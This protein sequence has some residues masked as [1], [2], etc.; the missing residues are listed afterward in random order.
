MSHKVEWYN[1]CLLKNGTLQ[2][3]S[4]I[5]SKYAVVGKEIVITTDGKKQDWT[6]HTVGEKVDGEYLQDRAHNSACIWTATSGPCP[7]GNK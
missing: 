6:V 1:Q 5:P 7:R 4:F 3:T 2:Y